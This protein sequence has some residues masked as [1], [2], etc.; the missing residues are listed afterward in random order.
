MLKPKPTAQT[1]MAHYSIRELYKAWDDTDLNTLLMGNFYEAPVEGVDIRPE[2]IKAYVDV[3]VASGHTVDKRISR[4]YSDYVLVED[5]DNIDDALAGFIDDNYVYIL[6]HN[7]ELT[8]MYDAL[9]SEFNPIENYDRYEDTSTANS[10]STSEH[11]STSNSM[12]TS[13]S[14]SENNSQSRSV[15]NSNTENVYGWDTNTANPVS[16]GNGGSGASAS[17]T[18]NIAGQSATGQSGT[19]DG[20]RQL[21]G[22]NTVTSHI[23]GNIGVTKATEMIADVLRL[24]TESGWFDVLVEKLIH[25]QCIIIDYGNNAL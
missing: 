7:A 12:T 23:H 24:Y 19:V 25:E 10:E 3:D 15:N 9:M 17:E 16:S 8:K 21:D 4:K 5:Y 6:T 1:T 20:G 14:E 2:F 11:T 18:R 22:L 13:T